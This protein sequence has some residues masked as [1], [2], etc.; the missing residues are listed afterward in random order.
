M[1]ALADNAVLMCKV[2]WVF[3][4]HIYDNY[5]DYHILGTL[6]ATI[7]QSPHMRDVDHLMTSDVNEWRDITQ[8][9]RQSSVLLTFLNVKHVRIMNWNM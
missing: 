3:A 9:L 6:F 5:H 7:T 4:G 2:L 8:N 1:N